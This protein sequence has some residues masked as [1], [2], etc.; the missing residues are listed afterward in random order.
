MS[1]TRKNF[2]LVEDTDESLKGKSSGEFGLNGPVHF[3]ELTF[4]TDAGKDKSPG[5]AVD[6]NV[7][8][9]DREYKRRIYD[10]SG[11]PQLDKSGNQVQPGEKGYDDLFANTMS[12]GIAV[13][14]HALKAVGVTDEQIKAVAATL[15][16]DA[17]GEGM[18]KLIA[19]APA[20]YKSK[21]IDA[22]LEYQWSISE[23][24]SQTFLELPKNM[25]GGAFLLPHTPPV[26][27]WTERITEEGNL[28]YFDN[29]GNIHKFNRSK[30]YME[31]PKAIQ[32]GGNSQNSAMATVN[33]SQPQ[34]ETAKKSTW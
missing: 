31:S 21:P 10:A 30:D 6:I 22:F 2:F 7:M 12:Q 24:Q 28:E 33:G 18:G 26:G 5:L 32:Q 15:S 4:V 25:K 17:V 20:D 29:Q 34:A 8:V 1:E 9:K 19:L 23:G 11:Q 27:K 13:I 16:L 14:K 3:S